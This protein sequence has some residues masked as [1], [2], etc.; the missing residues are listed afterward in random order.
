MPRYRRQIAPGSVQHVISRFVDREFRLDADGA[1]DE[2]LHRAGRALARTDWRALAFALM[3]SHVH[4]ALYAGS[5]PSAA[6]VKPLH[7]GFAGWLNAR[8]RRLGPVFADRHRS[9]T[10]EG[11]TAAALIAY[12]H[13]NPV[14]AGV[15][16]DPAHS[17]W[18]SH[19]AYL[20]IAEPP[21]WLDI[22]LGLHLCG[23]A[24]TAPGRADFHAFVQA[25]TDR[26]RSLE[27][28]GGDLQRHRSSAR[29]LTAT[30]LEVAAPRVRQGHHALELH[31]PIVLPD[32]CTIRQ[33]W[34]GEPDAILSA[35]AQQTGL[36]AAEL[37]ER[38]RAHNVVAAR[39]LAL[40]TWARYLNRP[41]VQIARVLGIAESSASQLIAT[42]SPGEHERAAVLA[43]SLLERGA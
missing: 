33:H 20:G 6:F 10:C 3:S 24:A 41:A 39:R 38:G 27:L 15:V 31:V 34:R 13:N 19:R 21:P 32:A 2:Y 16:S 35:A 42:A 29:K 1:R 18:T 7:S 40:L 9:V 11:E 28:N 4:W 37:R 25:R 36:T 5:T 23:F 17:G 22:D 14:R 43:R 30:P 26:P 8:Q 12:V